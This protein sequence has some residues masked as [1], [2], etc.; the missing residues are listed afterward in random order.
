MNSSI[1]VAVLCFYEELSTNGFLFKNSDISIGANLL[2]SSVDLYNYGKANAISF[3]TLDQVSSLDSLDAVIFMDR[4]RPENDCAKQVIENARISKYLITYENEM[5]KPD[6]WDVDFHNKCDRIF[7]WN[8]SLVDGKRYVKINYAFDPLSYLDF[9]IIKKSFYQRKLATIISGAKVFAH[10]LELYS[11]RVRCIRWF[12]A[13]APQD[14]DLY[15]VGWDS[16][17][18]PSYR[19]I[20]K[21][22]LATLSQYK[23]V[24]CYEN[25]QGLP[26]YITEKIIDCFRAGTVPIYGGA[27]NISR[28]IPSNCY[29]NIGQFGTYDE[30]YNYIKTMDHVMYVG[31]LD[32]IERFLNCQDV[33]PFSS[34]CF[35][36]TI[37]KFIKFDINARR[38]KNTDSVNS[39]AVGNTEI[40]IVQDLHTMAIDDNVVTHFHMPPYIDVGN[41]NLFKKLGRSDLIVYFGYGDELSIYSRAR[42]IW[43]FYLLH[44]PNIK[45]IFVRTT[46]VM[47]RG[48]VSSNGYDVLVGIGNDFTTETNDSGY[49]KTGVWSTSE[50]EEVI[51]RQV[52]VYDYLLRKHPGHFYLYNPTITSIIDFRG[53]FSA[54]EK[55]PSVGCFAGQPGRLTSPPELGGLSFICG[56][57]TLLSRDLVQRL[58]DSYVHGHEWNKFP[59][60]IWQS[61]LLKDVIRIPMPYFSFIKRRLE[62]KKLDEVSRIMR[63][64]I[65]DGHFHFRIKSSSDENDLTC[66]EDVDPWIML[67]VISIILETPDSSD[68]TKDLMSKMISL[69]GGTKDGFSAYPDD[70]FF[71]GPRNFPLNDEEA[72][73]VYPA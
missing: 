38:N 53:L 65:N 9:S 3:V 39:S 29:I 30:L 52:V 2:Q 36:N 33:Y 72:L 11:H 66:R 25:A 24:I 69:T 13:T 5:I 57:N 28:W 22:K 15:G 60:D 16:R 35:S 73:I 8:D 10:P 48:E 19:G 27:P 41:H 64:L 59:N 68:R 63:H 37:T 18:F 40:S 17:S 14:F 32:S 6:N 42:A 26:G 71:K 54:L 51:Y 31:Y 70:G 55:L 1:I 67:K 49:A 56:T 20:V 46:K 43:A 50:N 44:F 34:V 62:Y 47:S 45:S 4:P 7:T 21:D 61:L 12:E 23:F 58:R